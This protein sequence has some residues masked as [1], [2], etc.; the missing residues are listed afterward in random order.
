[1]AN[2][3][4]YIYCF[5]LPY[6]AITIGGIAIVKV[7][8]LLLSAWLFLE[9]GFRKFNKT[10]LYT[11]LLICFAPIYLII[12]E[13]IRTSVSDSINF[14]ST[15][16]SNILLFVLMIFSSH[17]LNFKR[18]VTV[19]VASS[20]IV[21]LVMISPFSDVGEDGRLSALGLNANFS[22]ILLSL[23]FMY[24][25]IKARQQKTNLYSVIIY[26][27]ALI[28]LLG[29]IGT[30]T[31]FGLLVCAL[32]I[33][34]FFYKTIAFKF[35][36]VM[37]SIATALVMSAGIFFAIGSDLVVII[38]L[39]ELSETF[40]TEGRLVLW[41][42]AIDSVGGNYITGIGPNAFSDFIVPIMGSYMS[43]HNV[44]FEFY[45]YGGIFGIIL[46]FPIVYIAISGVRI[47]SNTK[48]SNDLVYF[49]SIILIVIIMLHHIVFNKLFWFLLAFVYR[50]CHD[51]RSLH[52]NTN[53][54]R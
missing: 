25:S 13:T 16:I 17:A 32:F 26:S 1:M 23:S 2:I 3:L 43:P 5:S 50:T 11:I 52:E 28:P 29:V 53:S 8:G 10:D 27:L 35:G 20:F 47:N 31:R 37:A 48:G 33:C 4:L 22:A 39:L 18:G 9:L 42:L 49:S 34:I 36:V 6:Q 46:S 38:R 30:G 51:L 41:G 45:I 44:F 14:Y 40:T 21:P 19:L 12:I 54:S 7:T 15:F 24:L